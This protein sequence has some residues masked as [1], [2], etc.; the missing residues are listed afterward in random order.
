MN[1]Y[2]VI[3]KLIEKSTRSCKD[4]DNSSFSYPHEPNI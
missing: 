4:V 1:I 3:K 2:V